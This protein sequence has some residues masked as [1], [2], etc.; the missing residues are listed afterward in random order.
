MFNPF[1]IGN[2]GPSTL[3]TG[4]PRSGP[5]RTLDGAYPEDHG[6]ERGK[7]EFRANFRWSMERPSSRFLR[8]H[9]F[10]YNRLLS[11][12]ICHV[13]LSENSVDERFQSKQSLSAV[14][15][16]IWKKVS[17]ERIVPCDY[18]FTYPYPRRAL[19][20]G[21]ETCNF[22]LSPLFPFTTPVFRQKIEISRKKKDDRLFFSSL[23][24]NMYHT[25]KG[26]INSW[27]ID[28]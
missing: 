19:I 25:F 26:L 27:R 20:N 4:S 12:T 5:I 23:F 15:N 21:S 8:Q 13:T 2:Y 1:S 16:N 22:L 3:R 7:I 10:N 18:F 24:A 28:K 11:R 9:N 6:L 14:A 17:Q